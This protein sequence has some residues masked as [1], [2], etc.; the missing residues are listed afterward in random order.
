MEP[1]TLILT[2]LATGATAG[3]LHEVKGDTQQAAHAAMGRLRELVGQRFRESGTPNSEAILAE[4]DE[5]PDIYQAPLARKLEAADAGNDDAL[6]AAAQ[7]V[8]ELLQQ[9]GP[10]GKYSV[11]M[12]GSEGVQ[13]GDGNAQTN[14]FS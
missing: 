12:S 8:L 3:V 10:S 6:V 14:T 5:D 1:L 7:E 11:T 4:F 13:I 2:A 9:G